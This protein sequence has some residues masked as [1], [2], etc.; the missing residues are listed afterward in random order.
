MGESKLSSSTL[1]CRSERESLVNKG[2]GSSVR[3]VLNLG[4]WTFVVLRSQSDVVLG[5]RS[6]VVPGTQL[7]VVPWSRCR[8]LSVKAG[9]SRLQVHLHYTTCLFGNSSTGG[10]RPV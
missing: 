1:S 10:L 9:S 8:K 4:P 7:E 3:W 6:D 5:T 2:I